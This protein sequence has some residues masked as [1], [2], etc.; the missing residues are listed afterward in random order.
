M[1]RLFLL[2]RVREP[3]THKSAVLK[4]AK[5]YHHYTTK[6]TFGGGGGG[7]GAGGCKDNSCQY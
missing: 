7:P 3:L 1:S 4:I 6:H 5:D 2:S